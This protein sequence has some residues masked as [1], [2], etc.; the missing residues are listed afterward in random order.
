MCERLAGRQAFRG[1]TA[2]EVI[3]AVIHL[4]APPP[5]SLNAEVSP[6]LDALVARC[7]RK[8]PAQRWGAMA[9]VRR[10][11]KAIIGGTSMATAAMKVAAIAAAAPAPRRRWG[12]R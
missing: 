7:M 9:D 3:S 8:E 1:G 2:I 4:E 12:L 10:E 6:E 5:S 11:L